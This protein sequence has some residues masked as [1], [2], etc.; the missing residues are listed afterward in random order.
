[1]EGSAWRAPNAGKTAILEQ[2]AKYTRIGATPMEAGYTET[3]KSL[4]SDIARITGVPQFLLEDL[5]RAT[6]NNIEELSKLF[7]DLHAE[8]ALCFNIA[9][10]LAWKLLPENEKANHEIRFDFSEI[11]GADVESQSKLIDSLMKWGVANRDE[12]RRTQGMPPIEDGSGKAYY[13]PLNM[14]DPTKEPEEIQTPAPAQNAT[15]GNE[16]D[17]PAGAN[18]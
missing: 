10:E 12:V 6:F 5:D 15:D 8:T 2:G 16:E 4:V 17:T 14:V 1:M 9:A 3:K 13:I 7:R 18:G 11:L